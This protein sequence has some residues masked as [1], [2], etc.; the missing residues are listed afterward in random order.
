MNNSTDVRK[1][2]IAT[3][4]SKKFFVRFLYT[5]VR[6]SNIMKV[7]STQKNLSFQPRFAQNPIVQ[8]TL[9][10]AKKTNDTVA[11]KLLGSLSDNGV[12]IIQETQ[13]V[14]VKTI[15][16]AEKEAQ[17]ILE[18]HPKREEILNIIRNSNEE[19][20]KTKLEFLK[21]IKNITMTEEDFGYL[22]RFLQGNFTKEPLIA[23]VWGLCI[24]RG[25]DIYTLMDHS[26][27]I[28]EKCAK[29]ILDRNL[30]DKYKTSPKRALLMSRFNSDETRNRVLEYANKY[31]ENSAPRIISQIPA[32]DDAVTNASLDLIYRFKK[33][34][35]KSDSISEQEII[36]KW[37]ATP[38]TLEDIDSKNKVLDII[39]KRA[40]VEKNWYYIPPLLHKTDSENKTII[41]K[42]AERSD[43]SL[44][45]AD[46]IASLINKNNEE[47]ISNICNKNLTNIAPNKIPFFI[48]KFNSFNRTLSNVE[49][50]Q[51]S[52]QIN[53]LKDLESVPAELKP[54][55]A[56]HGYDVDYYISVINKMLG[57]K[58]PVV[59]V[60][61]ELQK[62]FLSAFL[63]NNNP[64]A[65]NI[66]KNHEFSQYEKNGIPLKYSRK[67]FCKNINTIISKLTEEEQ[68]TLIEHFG[69]KRGQN[70]TDGSVS[71]DGI[72]NNRKFEIN[73]VRDEVKDAANCISEEIEK[74]TVKNE[75]LF[76]DTELKD[77]FDAIIKGLPEFTAVIGKEQHNV[78][79]YSVDI[80]T[81]KVLQ[82]AMN[83]PLYSTLSDKDKTVLK[84]SVLLHDLGKSGGKRDEGHANTSA[85]FAEGILEKINFSKDVKNRITDIVQ[86]HH[87]FAKYNMGFSSVEDVAVRCRRP[88]DLK[89]YQIMAKADLENVNK[90]FHLGDKSGGAKT[91]AEFDKYME[92]KMKPIENVLNQVYSRHNPVFYT[93]FIGNGKLFPVEK[94][95]IGDEEVELRVLDLNKLSDNATL[96]QYGFPPGTTKEN[97]RFLV[98]MTKPNIA[99][100]ESVIH[101]TKNRLNHNTWSTSIIKPSDNVTYENLAFGF[102]FHVDQANFADA[103]FENIATG[104]NKTLESF[105]DILLGKI[106]RY[107]T[108]KINVDLTQE[109][110]QQLG[111]IIQE[112]SYLKNINEDIIIGDKVIN[113]KQLFDACSGDS[114]LYLRDIMLENLKK[115]GFELSDNEYADL[116][117]FLLT[118]NYLTQITKP[119][120]KGEL[121]GQPVKIGKH[122]IPASILVDCLNKTLDRLFDNKNAQ[123]EVIALDPYPAAL[124]AKVERLEQCHPCFLET[125]KKYR[126]TIPVIIQKDSRSV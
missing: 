101:L 85:H 58:V 41:T 110:C 20:Q 70:Y 26:Y 49:K 64:A 117:K 40:D 54:V 121:T 118:K 27:S 125:A 119:N 19:L 42:I 94:I 102:A 52:E 87:W 104:N 11:T 17:N 1:G 73:N 103:F 120:H 80:H 36:T 24:Q 5:I 92:E 29:N 21:L 7:Y 116:T 65:E 6:K 105:R 100:L 89:I 86:N 35:D 60:P 99:S 15:T 38:V 107:D 3:L 57:E 111:K 59:R 61:S 108:R 113:Q 62:G 69:L 75:S 12:N 39:E 77:I 122:S 37:K 28:N 45:D 97:V 44:K 72:L 83:N 53:I 126:D 68:N 8:N 98:H 13:D 93:R 91:Q 55:F 106:L 82:S 96:E 79:A 95:K 9:K 23:K 56:K 2:I 46:K 66:L 30:L 90:Y 51:L 50:L 78:H 112:K 22:L 18:N 32:H 31:G 63:S 74:F 124:I 14:F 115:D 67:D 4:I 16:K 123:S 81:L 48:E 34:I 71:Y 10:I 25:V 47:F 84:M 33:L 114:W 109:E 88:G 76:E 43:I